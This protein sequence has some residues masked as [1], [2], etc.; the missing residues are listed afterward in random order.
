VPTR[1]EAWALLCEWTQGDALRKHGRAVEGAV[2]WYAQN[3]FGKSGEELE[4]WRSA[5]LLHDF[6]YERYPDEHPLRG[7]DELRGRG[8]PEELV[9]A[10]L[11][12]GDHTGVPR[13]TD[14]AHTVYACDEMSGFVIAVT[15]VRPSRSLDEV[16]P[17]AVAKKMKDRGICPAGSARPAGQRRGR[18]G[19]AVRRSRRERDRG[20]QDRP[21]RPRPIASAR[22]RP[23][24]ATYDGAVEGVGVASGS[25]PT[26]G[27]VGR[28]D[29][30]ARITEFLDGASSNMRALLLEGDPGIGKTT[31]W[32][33]G[34]GAARDRGYR[35]LTA[36]PA[37]A[38][39]Q[40]A[41]GALSDLLEAVGADELTGV[42]APQLH[43][44]EVALLRSESGA[45]SQTV[46]VA[47]GFTTALRRA[48]RGPT[49]A[50]RDRRCSMA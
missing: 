36:R 12:H 45:V 26:A 14:L 31:L 37:E 20:P 7:A 35:V 34:V 8:Y 16:D 22:G 2:G 3:R 10:V 43:A 25:M 5:G 17:R 15:L 33:L 30:H 24:T 39:S 4:V 29:E 6:D 46:A 1:D 50:R 48:R 49:R 40:L 38:E 42:P 23:S 28:D 19:C 32:E 44:L 13:T 41:Y 18:A 27:V 47:A 21:R 11:G 9:Q